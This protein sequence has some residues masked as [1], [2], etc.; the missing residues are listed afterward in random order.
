MNAK[1]SLPH[2]RHRSTCTIFQTE[3][4]PLDSIYAFPPIRNFFF[5]PSIYWRKLTR[6][7][8]PVRKSMKLSYI[9]CS[10]CH[11]VVKQ[12]S[13]KKQPRWTTGSF[14][15]SHRRSPIRNMTMQPWQCHDSTDKWQIRM[16]LHNNHNTAHFTWPQYTRSQNTR[17]DYTRLD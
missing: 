12:K 4:K 7:K 3:N 14:S 15:A 17:L 10:S 13:F 6:S 2:P 8:S 11:R 1:L 5:T 9:I 16:Y